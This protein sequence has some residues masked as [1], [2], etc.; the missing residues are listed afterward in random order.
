MNSRVLFRSL[1]VLLILLTPAALVADPF[2]GYTLVAPMNST[3]TLLVDMDGAEVHSWPSPYN[4]GLAAYLLE[5]G[6]VLR[7]GRLGNPTFSAGGS[8]GQIMLIDW[9][10]STA[11]SYEY[12]TASHCQHHDVEMMPSGNVLI[13]AWELKSR[14]EAEDAGRNPAWIIDN[15]LWP[16]TII[17]VQPDGA[18]GGTVVWE[19]RVWDHLVQ[20]HDPA[21]DNY[22]VVAD[23]PELANLNH[24]DSGAQ[25]DW[26]HINS[27]A[28]NETFD[29]IVVSVHN[30]DEVW[31]IDHST[32]TAEAAGH[33]GGNSGR[34]GDILYRWG[35]PQAYDAG[36]E[37]DRKFFGQHDAQWI[38]G[39]CPGAGNILVFNNGPGRPEGNYS[40]VDEIEPPVDGSGNYAYTP[41]SAY[42][43]AA[44]T[45]V[46]TASPPTSFF[47]SGIS[48]A[49]RLPDGNT[50]ICEGDSNY[51]FEV[52]TAMVT[53]WDYNAPAHVFK[54]RRFAPS[55]PGL[56]RLFTIGGSLACSPGSGILPFSS[57]FTVTL[58]NR[59]D[60]Q[61]RR[62]AGRIDVALAN[63]ANYP[64]WRA[65]FTNMAPGES[66]VASW[67]QS[68][69][70]LGSL[71]GVNTFTL[72][73][74][75][76]TPVP[77]NQPPY[78]ASGD[79]AVDECT[80]SCA[81]PAPPRFASAPPAS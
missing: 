34:G 46:Y 26:T 24:V 4:P 52:D 81:T 53:Q 56:S 27:V 61:I 40:T 43:P 11:W 48:G 20:D 64:S 31:V 55:F 72:A 14:Q 59:Y 79:T 3:T 39:D 66:Y 51:I 49:E 6:S 63:G 62:L 25:A 33:S 73:A 10:G 57:L 42:L 1:L 32:T 36:S 77:Y 74:E 17:E 5:E 22:G 68:F 45:W 65:G 54:A 7:S 16:D 21:M 29:Q 47:S 30:F 69:P 28:Y 70:A 50:L 78:P 75:D 58:S 67:V 9:D 2:D 13:V 35:N 38:A 44:Q 18:T 15:V 60:G 12:S 71:V 80:V 76:V 8:G 23:H 37:A 19:W 41:G